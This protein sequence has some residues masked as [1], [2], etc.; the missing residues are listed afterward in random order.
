LE[1]EKGFIPLDIDDEILIGGSK[2]L[3]RGKNAIGSAWEFGGGHGS[4]S[5]GIAYALR[6]AFVVGGYDNAGFVDSRFAFQ[7]SCECQGPFRDA[8][9]KRLSAEIL[10]WFFSE[11][12]GVQTGWNCQK[13]S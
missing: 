11:A 9:D 10:K 13:Y 2:G 12:C 3:Q 4:V 5:T 1:R 7:L 8:A 6:D